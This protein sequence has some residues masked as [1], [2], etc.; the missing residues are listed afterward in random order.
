MLSHNVA[1]LAAVLE[2][3]LNHLRSLGPNKVPLE[4]SRT[5]NLFVVLG[6]LQLLR[7]L[8]DEE[9]VW[10]FDFASWLTCTHRNY[11]PSRY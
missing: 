10:R 11:S 4:S 8:I 5:L 9:R 1:F 3:R 6:E 2:F 7:T